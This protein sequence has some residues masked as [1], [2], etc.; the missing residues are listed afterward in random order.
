MSGYIGRQAV[1][2]GAGMAGLA[3]AG[4]LSNHFERVLVLDRDDLPP[5]AVHRSGTPQSRHVH[6]LLSGGL[7]AL[8]EMFPGFTSRLASAGGVE[9]DFPLDMW[10]ERGGF[11]PFPRRKL[12]IMT[13]CASRP[14]IE[15]TTRQL[16]EQQPNIL[17]RQGCRVHE[18]LATRDAAI[19]TGVRC[20]TANGRSEMIPA[21][22]V[23]DASGRGTLTLELLKSIGRSVPEET[24]IGM[25]IGY[26]TGTFEIPDD[27]GRN[28]K[29]VATVPHA[30][31]SS[32]GAV[33]LPRE[34]KQW[35]LTLYGMHD[36]KPP[37]DWDGFLSYAKSLR[38]QT[39]YNA[40]SIA[41]R[42]GEIHR[43]ALPASV[44]RHFERL[45]DF[46]RGLIPIGDAICRFNP[47]FGQ[48][49]SVAA[50][51]AAHL[52]RLLSARAGDSEPLAGLARSYFDVVQ[53]L[54]KTPWSAA[55]LDLVHPK[56][57]GVTAT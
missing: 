32:R 5:D 53:D 27:S 48:G 24:S 45:G 49:M 43:F 44:L 18:I 20:E 17:F 31:Q 11:S 57:S 16:V 36:D 9:I 15:F 19:V 4:T 14:L 30:P 26:S 34:G 25:D 22:L 55:I 23:I 21:D 35:T 39:V 13:Y 2:I 8:N 52:N 47:V 42:I 54:I 10:V 56:T 7:R 38:T 33:M 50:I 51:E 28:W 3:A 37:G 1:V 41:R 6:G 12:N 29:G 46:P 40:I